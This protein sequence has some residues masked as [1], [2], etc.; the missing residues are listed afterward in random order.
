MSLF[1]LWQAD[2]SYPHG[3]FEDQCREA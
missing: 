2:P 3:N 1:L